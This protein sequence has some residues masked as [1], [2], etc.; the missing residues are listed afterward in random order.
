MTPLE[1]MTKL[2]GVSTPPG[3]VVREMW[4][5]ANRDRG[6]TRHI[7]VSKEGATERWSYWVCDCCGEIL[8][9]VEVTHADR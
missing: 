2:A 3:T 7:T 4:S 6:V 1:I 5:D 9:D 8:S